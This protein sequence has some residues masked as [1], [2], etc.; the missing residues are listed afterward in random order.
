MSECIFCK[1]INGEI[2]SDKVYEDE[3]VIAFNDINPQAP[4]HILVIPKEHISSIKEID[5]N[6]GDIIKHIHLVINRIAK[7]KGLD[8]KGFRIVNNCG[9]EG[10]QTVGHLHY[11]LLG[12]RQLQWP[13]G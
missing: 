2:P 12:G 8:E 10:G 11:H 7:E 4:V 6:N 5:E 9:E 3:K 1:I 13:P